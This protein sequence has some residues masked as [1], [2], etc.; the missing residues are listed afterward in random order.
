M[1]LTVIV[2]TWVDTGKGKNQDVYKTVVKNFL[3]LWGLSPKIKKKITISTHLTVDFSRESNT[4]RRVLVLRT[5]T[6]GTLKPETSEIVEDSDHSNTEVQDK[7]RTKSKHL[8][9]QNKTSVVGGSKKKKKKKVIDSNDA[10][11]GSTPE[12]KT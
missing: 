12:F 7:S 5:Q 4:D 10:N 8:S 1:L 3:V 9:N 11:H 2:K 6:S